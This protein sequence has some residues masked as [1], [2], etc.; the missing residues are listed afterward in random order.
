[1]VAKLKALAGSENEKEMADLY[2]GIKSNDSIKD[3]D[4][5]LKFCDLVTLPED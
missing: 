4:S 5:L 3:A 1:M 2:N